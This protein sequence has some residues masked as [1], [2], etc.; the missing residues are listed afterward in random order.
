MPWVYGVVHNISPPL[1]SPLSP[2]SP[3]PSPF[4]PLPLSPFNLSWFLQTTKI[5]AAVVKLF[6]LVSFWEF[7][8]SSLQL[9]FYYFQV[10]ASRFAFVNFPCQIVIVSVIGT[11]WIRMSGTLVKKQT[12]FLKN[13]RKSIKFSA[14]HDMTPLYLVSFGW[15]L[16]EKFT[17]L[18]F[19][20]FVF[21]NHERVMNL[22]WYSENV[23]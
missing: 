1:P 19:R 13:P 17:K 23:E 14:L 3:L 12:M 2:L 18:N 8:S 10:I 20:C 6:L 22:S 11:Y 16:G 15:E 7:Q 21:A 4:S 9:H 5:H